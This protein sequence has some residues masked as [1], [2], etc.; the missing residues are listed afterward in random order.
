MLNEDSLLKLS[1]LKD[2]CNYAWKP[3]QTMLGFVFLLY[4]YEPLIYI[5]LNN[6]FYGFL[7]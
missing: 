6:S 1:L 7:G 2:V 4:V 3:L 5:Q